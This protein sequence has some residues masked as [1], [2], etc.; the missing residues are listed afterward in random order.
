VWLAATE[1][2][3]GGGQF[4][5]DRA[6]RPDHYQPYTRDRGGEAERLWASV[7]DALSLD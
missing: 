4:W 1:P 6:P 7:R 5:H 2:A 3:P